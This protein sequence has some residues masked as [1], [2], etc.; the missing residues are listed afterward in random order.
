MP[1]SCAVLL[2]LTVALLALFSVIAP[3]AGQTAMTLA[4]GQRLSTA[5]P[6]LPSPLLGP[7]SSTSPPRA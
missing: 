6:S 7:P 3:V 2:S 5:S 1:L 4:P